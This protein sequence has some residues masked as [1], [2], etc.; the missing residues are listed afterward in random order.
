L[1]RVE[2]GPFIPQPFHTRE[3]GYRFNM[4]QSQ[5]PCRCQLN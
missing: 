3:V 1:N 2:S 5:F 4:E